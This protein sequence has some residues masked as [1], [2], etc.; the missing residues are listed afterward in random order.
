MNPTRNPNPTR[1]RKRTHT[2]EITIKIRIKSMTAQG[3]VKSLNSMPV[4]PSP[5]YPCAMK[6]KAGGLANTRSLD[7]VEAQREL[8][9]IGNGH[10]TAFCKKLLNFLSSLPIISRSKVTLDGRA[11][12][13]TPV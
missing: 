10:S 1:N 2:E 7:L 6:R 5:D 4:P 9:P 13:L 12:I 11:K 3:K 8:R